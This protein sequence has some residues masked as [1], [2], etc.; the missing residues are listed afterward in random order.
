METWGSID[1]PF[2]S[3]N[4][5]LKQDQPTTLSV[6][7][8]WHMIVKNRRFMVATNTSDV[9]LIVLYAGI[10]T[11]DYY[12]AKQEH[13]NNLDSLSRNSS[14]EQPVAAFSIPISYLDVAVMKSTN[15][16][17]EQS[18]GKLG[19]HIFLMHPIKRS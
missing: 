6:A 1:M 15:L 19:F 7:I 3:T 10:L 12:Y 17:R 11:I 5:H 9:Y 13:S 16:P 2:S 4:I 14:S 8:K 18:K